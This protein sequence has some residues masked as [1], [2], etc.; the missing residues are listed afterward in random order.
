MHSCALC[1]CAAV[2]L[3]GECVLHARV[4]ENSLCVSMLAVACC[5]YECHSRVTGR[6]LRR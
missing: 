4:A 6:Q 2:R 1:V 3:G 5:I